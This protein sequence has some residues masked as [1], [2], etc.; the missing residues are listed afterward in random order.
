MQN[1]VQPLWN[2]LEVVKLVVSTLTP[3]A[4]LG[5]GLWVNRKLK[6]IEQLQWANQKVVEHRLKIYNE[7]VP[8]LNDILCYFTYIGIWKDVTPPEMVKL[9]RTIDKIVYVNAP[10]FPEHFLKKYN[11]FI[12]LV[13]KTFSGWGQD[14]KL[15]SKIERRREAAREQWNDDWDEYFVSDET[16]YEPIKIKNAYI[17]FISFFADEL[18]LGLKNKTLQLGKSPINIK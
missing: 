14:A 2:S 6:R 18:G 10:L 12:N 7:L 13:Y 9:K 17:E 3:L 16:C 11:K 4:V 1:N 15:R 5:L 8:Q